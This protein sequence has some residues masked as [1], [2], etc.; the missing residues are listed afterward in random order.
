MSRAGVFGWALLLSSLGLAVSAWADFPQ[1]K[2]SNPNP[3]TE[4]FSLPLHHGLTI[5]ID[6]ILNPNLSGFEVHV[7]PDSNLPFAPWSIY[8]KNLQPYDTDL[9]HLPYRNGVFSFKG[10]TTYCVKIRALYGNAV[11]PW[12]EQCGYKIDP[13]AVS[14]GDS[15][16]ADSDQDGLSDQAEY[17]AGSDPR[18]SDTDHD[19]IV[20]GQDPDLAIATGPFV[21]QTPAL[22]VKTPVI[23]FGEGDPF[24]GRPNQHKSIEVE[25]VGGGDVTITK[26]DILDGPQPGGSAYFRASYPLVVKA[27]TPGKVVHIPVSFYPKKRGDVT[28]QIKLTTNPP[29]PL[30]AIVASG[31]GVEIPDCWIEPAS[32]DFGSVPVNDQKVL[33]KELTFANQPPPGDPQPPNTNTPWG[34]TL[35]STIK[36]MAPGIRGFV[37][38][39]GESIKIPVLFQH[40]EV[41]KF[42]GALQVHSA[43]C[44]I[45]EVKLSGTVTEA[46][47]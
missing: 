17:V 6:P 33:T 4:K 27:T 5:V 31:I 32:L 30:S 34:F 29:Q 22:V 47:K 24:G 23:N 9:I 2:I 1:V 42:A 11:T 12:T 7:K 25:A 36:G 39:K 3:A 26:I 21:D 37:L 28:V 13:A 15:E 14:L 45:Q 35:M 18:E 20:D 38:Q 16:L 19:G 8:S 10:N 41:G 43:H 44:G 46:V 40:P